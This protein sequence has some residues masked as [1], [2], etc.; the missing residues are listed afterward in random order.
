MHEDFQ[1]LFQGALVFLGLELVDV[2]HGPSRSLI[3][4][5]LVPRV[6]SIAHA[7]SWQTTRNHAA[8]R[9]NDLVVGVLPDETRGHV[10]YHHRTSLQTTSR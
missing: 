1:F 4:I 2:A 8:S 3:G 6:D 10:F 9:Q 5:L 7:V